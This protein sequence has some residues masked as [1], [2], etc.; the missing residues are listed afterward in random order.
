M[1]TLQ[2]IL[3]LF[4]LFI[5]VPVIAYMLGKFCTAGYLRAKRRD[6]YLRSSDKDHETKP[7]TKP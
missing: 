5:G 3:L 7:Q 2:L 1:S 4:G 6:E